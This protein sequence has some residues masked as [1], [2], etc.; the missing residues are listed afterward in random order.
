[1]T[2]YDDVLIKRFS[3]ETGEMADVVDLEFIGEMKAI[4]FG[5]ET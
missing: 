3:L 1:M 2:E 5:P 4:A